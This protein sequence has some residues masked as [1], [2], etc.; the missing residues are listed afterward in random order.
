[1]AVTLEI[2]DGNPWYL[3]PN[4]W[5]VPGDDPEGP[6]GT[7]VAGKPC[8]LWARVRNTGKDRANNA[9]VRCYW[10]NPSVGFDRNSANVVG[11]A[12]VSLNGGQSGDVLC[13][14]PWVPV[15]VNDGH[16]CILAEVYHDPLDPLPG[17]S[18]FNVPTDRHVAQR[19]L[20]VVQAATARYF[21]FAFE[22]HNQHRKA[23]AFSLKAALGDVAELRVLLP[24]LG[25]KIE[26]LAHGGRIKDLGF[27]AAHYPDPDLVSRARPNLTTP[28]LRPYERTGYSLVG[29]LEGGAP[30]LVHVTQEFEGR[31]IGG[32][33]VLVLPV[34]ERRS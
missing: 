15:F 29:T 12:F 4:L 13:L 20:S 5:A 7:P 16:E 2:E 28:A 33:G 22:V 11:S 19:N 10:A 18:A 24:T 31:T 27:V 8:Y 3:S 9:T 30:A 6:A 26:T 1:M 32:L 34:E 21:I 17:V 23:R 14:T 25:R